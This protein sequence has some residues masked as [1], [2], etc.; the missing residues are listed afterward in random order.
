MRAPNAEQFVK[1]AYFAAVKKIIREVEESKNGSVASDLDSTESVI[2]RSLAF[3]KDE[4]TEWIKT[5]DWQRA[6][7]V[8]DMVKLLPVIDRYLPILATRKNPFEEGESSKLADKGR[9]GSCG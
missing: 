9:C 5:R 8:K 3:T 6:T 4:I 2:A 1:K 7:Q